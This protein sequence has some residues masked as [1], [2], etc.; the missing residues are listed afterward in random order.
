MDRQLHVRSVPLES[1][2]E[3]TAD[4]KT[5]DIGHRSGKFFR[6]AGF[7]VHSNFGP[8]AEWDQP[9]IDQPQIDVR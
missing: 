4:P 6:V 9:I 1:L 8:L 2:G 7:R 5:G 3:W